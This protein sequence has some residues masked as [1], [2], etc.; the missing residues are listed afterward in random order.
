MN[1]TLH[2]S[3]NELELSVEGR[4]GARQRVAVLGSQCPPQ[5]GICRV[6]MYVRL[7]VCLDPF[8]TLG[9][10]NGY[11]RR[12]KIDTCFGRECA[13]ENASICQLRKRGSRVLPQVV[14]QWM[15]FQQTS[16]ERLKIH[17]LQAIQSGLEY[18]PQ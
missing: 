18:H 13:E 16:L 2:P 14:S 10:Q 6:Q 1:A 7:S 15:N 9:N 5:T 4:A 11:L 3:S 17:V 8:G 12:P